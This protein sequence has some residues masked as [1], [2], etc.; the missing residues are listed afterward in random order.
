MTI[1]HL[2]I[3][4]SCKKNQLVQQKINL[5]S[6]ERTSVK[7]FTDV[8]VHNLCRLSLAL[9]L[10]L[11]ICHRCWWPKERS[12][13]TW[14][15]PCNR[16]GLNYQKIL[17][18]LAGKIASIIILAKVKSTLLL[19]WHQGKTNVC[20]SVKKRKLLNKREMRCSEKFTTCFLFHGNIGLSNV[21][22][23]CSL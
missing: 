5:F 20:Y 16:F 12:C 11:S 2:P 15:C 9:F 21:V 10:D 4:A 8:M 6:D 3:W 22:N 17:F 13:L 1:S 19:V 7:V 18:L 14:A 23:K